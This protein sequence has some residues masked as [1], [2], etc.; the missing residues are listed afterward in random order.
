MAK[1]LA[2]A[3]IPFHLVHH[4]CNG[5]SAGAALAYWLARKR[6]DA[7]KSAERL[8]VSAPLRETLLPDSRHR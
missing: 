8:R 4:L 6:G 3:C 1:G 2:L 7:K 5:V